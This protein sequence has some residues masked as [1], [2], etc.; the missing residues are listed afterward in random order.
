DEKLMENA[1]QVGKY[2]HDELV[3]LK[4]KEIG[5]TEVRGLGLMVAVQLEDG[6]AREMAV[7]CLE[8]GYVINSIGSS[9]LRFLPPLGISTREVDGLIEVL[10]GLLSGR[11]R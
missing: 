3:K 6:G 2:F 11:K 10:E 5:I 1:A 9:I 8:R 4:E 7:S